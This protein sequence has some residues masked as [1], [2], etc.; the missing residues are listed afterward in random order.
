MGAKIS[1]LIAKA[2]DAIAN[3]FRQFAPPIVRYVVQ[4]PIRT[5]GHVLSGM[6][7]LVPGIITAPLLAMAGF[8]SRGIAAG[9][10]A[11]AIQSGMGAAIPAGGTFAVLQSAAMG[12]YG[13]AAVANVAARVVVGAEGVGAVVRAVRR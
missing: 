8:A 2:S 1:T 4:H 10:L 7:L 12:G 3:T 6:L 13:A 11:A 5:T 9:S